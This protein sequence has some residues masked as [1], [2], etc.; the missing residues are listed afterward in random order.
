MIDLHNKILFE[1][2]SRSVITVAPVVVI[3]DML[4]KKASLIDNGVDDNKNGKLPNTATKNHA[5]VVNKKICLRLS[6]NSFSKF[7]KTHKTPKKIVI[8]EAEMKL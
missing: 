1:A 5:R 6:F 4:S 2:F 3:P 7:V 8:K